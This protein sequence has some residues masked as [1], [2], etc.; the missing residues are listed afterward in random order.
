MFKYY[1]NMRELYPMREISVRER[2]SRP[3][4]VSLTRNA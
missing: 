2:E 1:F 4:C 3:K